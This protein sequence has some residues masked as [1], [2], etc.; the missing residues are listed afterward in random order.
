[1]MTNAWSAYSLHV[2]GE[3]ELKPI[4]KKK[5]NQGIFGNIPTGVTIVDGLSTLY[6]M[7]L[8]KD[9]KKGRNW[10]EKNLNFDLVSARY[11]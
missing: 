10:I 7:G 4:T 8:Q 9:F 3:N 1:M 6:I 5:H 11:Q 2:W